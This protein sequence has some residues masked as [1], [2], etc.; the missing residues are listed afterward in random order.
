MR[1]TGILVAELAL[2]ETEGVERSSYLLQQ[3]L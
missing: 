3:G 1:F 2:N